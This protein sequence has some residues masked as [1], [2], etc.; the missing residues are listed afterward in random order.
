MAYVWPEPMSGCWLW[1]GAQVGGKRN[2]TP[3]GYFARRLEGKVRNILAH[4]FSYI[5]SG[6]EIPLGYE[7]DHLC[8]NTL[9]VNPDHLEAVTPL[10][11]RLRSSS[12]TTKNLRKTHCQNG[13]SLSG[14]NLRIAKNKDGSIKQRVCLQCERES[15]RRT[16]GKLKA[17]RWEKLGWAKDGKPEQIVANVN[18]VSM[19]LTEWAAVTGISYGTIRSRMRSGWPIEK[20]VTQPARPI[21]K[22]R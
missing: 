7:V 13:H 9:C 14:E 21:R 8:K 6:K 1:A 4:R 16:K 12:V 5:A 19:K 17:D 18:G 10:E 22:S 3:Y 20:A 11:N 15:H 2:K